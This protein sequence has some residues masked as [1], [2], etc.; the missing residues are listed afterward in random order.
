MAKKANARRYAQAVFEI[1][2]E[3]NELEQWQTYLQKVVDAIGD[4]DLLAAL[5]SPKIKLEDKSRFLKER[6]GKINPLV[7]NLALLLIS[8]SAVSIMGEVAQEYKRL[9][10]AHRGVKTADIVTAVP[11]DDVEKNKLATKLGEMMDAKVEISS[12]VDPAILGGM[13][14][15]IDGKLLDGSTNSKLLAL[16]KELA[17][18]GRR[19]KR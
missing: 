4:G 15:R 19:R 11:I 16:K 3:K 13:V 2:L 8:K 10:D 14:V 17:V 1:A 5:E 6:L 9:L 18:G 7:I 12:Q